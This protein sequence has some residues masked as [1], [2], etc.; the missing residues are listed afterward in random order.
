LISPGNIEFPGLFFLSGKLSA[1]AER[2]CL[3][4][5]VKFYVEFYSIFLYNI[6]VQN[7]KTISKKG[8]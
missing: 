5:A 6:Y 2:S 7:E 1:D 3:K 4:Y 8:S